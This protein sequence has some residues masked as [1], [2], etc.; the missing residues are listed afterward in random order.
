MKGAGAGRHA[1]RLLALVALGAALAAGPAAQT[2]M[3]GHPL[4]GALDELLDLYVRDGLVYYQALKQDRARL[5]RYARALGATSAETVRSWSRHEQLAFWINAYNA[6]VLQSV[7]DHY[8]I[9]G[10]SPD[11]PVDSLRQVPGAFERRTFTAGGRALTLD[12]IE[13]ERVASFG[14]PRALLAL[15]RSAR[16]GPRLRSE[17]YTGARLD[18]QLAEMAREAV[19][20]A[21]L[22]R[23]EA[24]RNLLSASALFSWREAA[25]ATWADRAPAVYQGR[26]ALERGI[27]AL[28]EPALTS[29]EAA[30]LHAN[31]FQTAFH[32][33]DWSLN[34]LTGR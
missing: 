23:V 28:I 4:H 22:V 21:T 30:F 34:D 11:Y 10:R 19:T 2:P 18:T 12:A 32:E 29:S 24:A 8:P 31:R 9:R 3:P 25:F 13:T 17:A 14:D 7:V 15:G 26:S 6:F 16:G 20:R 33:M 27:L 5:D 1:G